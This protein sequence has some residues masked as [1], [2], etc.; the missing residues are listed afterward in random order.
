[1]KRTGRARPKL[2]LLEGCLLGVALLL[3]V[4]YCAIAWRNPSSSVAE[5]LQGSDHASLQADLTRRLDLP[6]NRL[7]RTLIGILVDFSGHG[8][9]YRRRF[10]QLF[11]LHP[12]VCDIGELEDTSID[13]SHCEVVYAFVVGAGAEGRTMRL[14][15][16][17]LVPSAAQV[18]DSVPTQKDCLRS[19]MVLL[20][21][22]ENMNRGKSPTWLA[23][24]A[25][26]AERYGIDYVA[27]QDTDTILYLDR[28]LAFAR[29]N[30]PPAPFATDLW[31]GWFADKLTWPHNRGVSDVAVQRF[32]HKSNLTLFAQGQ[33]YLL[34]VDLAAR[35]AAAIPGHSRFAAQGFIEEHEDRDVASAVLLGAGPRLHLIF[36][37]REDAFWQHRV[38]IRLGKTFAI[39]WDKELQRLKE[40]VQREF[41]SDALRQMEARVAALED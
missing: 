29:R 1:M 16:P 9:R 36:I 30:L 23:Y 35:V 7:S 40:H 14:Q 8:Y 20:D 4:T 12:H 2:V 34:S 17:F 38:K 5:N 10:R 11:P 27:K 41:G 24:G 15:S 33:W 3:A 21:I 13:T 37:A 25:S 26:I 6:K 39:E 28:V 31:A 22:Q 19:D 32:T 18:C